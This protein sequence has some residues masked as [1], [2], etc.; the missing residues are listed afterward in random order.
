[1]NKAYLFSGQGSQYKGMDKLFKSYPRIS[2]LFFE[3]SNEILKYDIKKIIS[4]NPDNLLNST[5]HT[6]P[7]IFIISSIAYN[8]H[9]QKEGLPNCFAGHSLGEI[10]AL[11]AS[12]VISYKEALRFIKIRS[13]SMNNANIKNPGKMIAV[14]HKNMDELHSILNTLSNLSVANYNSK[15]QIILSGK[16]IDIDNAVSYLK[17]HKIHV[18]PLNVSG[19]FHSPLMKSASEALLETINNLNFN[20]AILPIYQNVNATPNTKGEVIKLNI[21]NQ[22]T[23]P[24]KWDSIISNMIKDG[25]NSF[26]ELGPKSILS[27][28]IKP[29]KNITSSSFEKKYEPI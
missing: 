9:V 21:I 24:V 5:K 3:T 28:L 16:E 23:S 29:S 6:Q 1:M 4:T 19:A 11:Y 15:N 17:K 20:D 10:T 18:V 7:A 13:E 8:I 25:V 12:K 26:F 2:N 14:L 22:I 27:K